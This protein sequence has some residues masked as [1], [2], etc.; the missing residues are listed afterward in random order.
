MRITKVSSRILSNNC[1]QTQL[2]RS[3]HAQDTV[4]FTGSVECTYTIPAGTKAGEINRVNTAVITKTNV[5]SPCIGARS[6]FLGPNNKIGLVSANHVVT[7]GNN[8]ETDYISAGEKLKIDN[9]AIVGTIDGN[10]V[11]I[12]NNLQADYI[13]GRNITIGDNATVFKI[14]GKRNIQP[15]PTTVKIGDNLQIVRIK[16]NHITLG[17]ITKLNDLVLSGEKPALHL[18]GAIDTSEPIK[19]YLGSKCKQLTIEAKEGLENVLDK[20]LF[21]MRNPATK[22]FRRLTTE[23]ISQLVKLVRV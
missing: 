21:L 2:K 18:N 22:K 23:E 13:A 8:L 16:A 1:V 6:I 14:Y 9:N 17:S 11:V 15:K 5:H 20:F 19:V 3:N 10:K 4:N 12:G 7:A